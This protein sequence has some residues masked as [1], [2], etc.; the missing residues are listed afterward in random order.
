M[1]ELW[2]EDGST[3]E[4]KPGVK[5]AAVAQDG[6]SLGPELLELCFPREVRNSDFYMNP[7]NL[8]MFVT[9]LER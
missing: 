9:N 6:G 4:H 8:S 7:L 2:G 5:R 3:S 1:S